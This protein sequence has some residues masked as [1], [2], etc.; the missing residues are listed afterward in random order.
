[1]CPSSVLALKL[2]NST[3]FCRELLSSVS[4]PSLET[5]LKNS[6]PFLN[7]AQTHGCHGSFLA[8]LALTLLPTTLAHFYFSRDR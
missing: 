6:V 8:L 3:P 5:K 1:M 7:S 2:F 4:P